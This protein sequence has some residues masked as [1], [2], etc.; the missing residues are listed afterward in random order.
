MCGKSQMFINTYLFVFVMFCPAS[1]NLKNSFVN[2]VLI[3]IR[4]ILY[5]NIKITIDLMYAHHQH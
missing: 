3:I 4:L 5:Y 2:V 1:K